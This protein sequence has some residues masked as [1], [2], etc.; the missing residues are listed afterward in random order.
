MNQCGQ[1]DGLLGDEC[2]AVEVGHRSI[3][4]SRALRKGYANFTISTLTDLCHEDYPEGWVSFRIPH[5]NGRRLRKLCAPRRRGA[6]REVNEYHISNRHGRDSVGI[7]P[8][9][10]S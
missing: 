3:P 5:G 8:T 6:L 7:A 9:A 10:E 1:G 2:C 4:G